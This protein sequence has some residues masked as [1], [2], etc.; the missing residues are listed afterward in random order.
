MCGATMRTNINIEDRL[1]AEAMTAPGLPTKEAAVEEA[2]QQL[3][4][5]YRQREAIA[6]MSGLGWD[7]DLGAMRKGRDA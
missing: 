5:R 1:I 6:D 7:G 2:L 3:I 4:S